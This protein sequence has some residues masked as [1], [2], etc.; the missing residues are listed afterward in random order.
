MVRAVVG[1]ARH[2]LRG[3]QPLI[4]YA[5]GPHFRQTNAIEGELGEGTG[6]VTEAAKRRIVLPFA[7]PLRTD[8]VLGHELV[9]AFQYDITN[10]NANSHGGAL[11]MPLW[12][13]EGMAEYSRSAR[14]IRNT[15]MWMREAARREKLPDIKDLDDPRYFPYRYGQ[16][17]W[18]F[19]GGRYGD[20]AIGNLLRGSNGRGGY[21]DAFK[22][23]LGV[24]WK[25]LSKQW[26]DAEIAA[27]RPIAEARRC[28]RHSPGLCHHLARRPRDECEP[29]AEPGWLAADVLLRAGSV[30]DRSLSRRHQYRKGDPEVTDTATVAGSRVIRKLP[31]ASSLPLLRSFRL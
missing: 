29:R 31:P 22:G 10:T 7:G 17:L 1:G 26:H 21:E 24:D 15:A 16:A 12:F 18:A 2:Q 19:I 30:L 3:R 11:T 25:E 20:R 4:L 27:Y 14:S 13:I 28:R 23:I 6:G 9:H 5:S 8:H